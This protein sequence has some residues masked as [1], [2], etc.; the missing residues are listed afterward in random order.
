V[1]GGVLRRVV[2][3]AVVPEQFAGKF[4]ERPGGYGRHGVTLD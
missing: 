1:Q 2:R 3:D 4:E